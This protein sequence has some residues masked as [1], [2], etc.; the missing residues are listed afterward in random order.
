MSKETKIP[1]NPSA[2]SMPIVNPDA[3]GVDISATMHAVAVPPDRDEVCTREFGAF[4]QDLISIAE[5]LKKCRITTVAMESTGVYWKPLYTVLLEYGFSVALVNA[6]HV[7]NVTGR[8]NDM[9]D[10]RWIQKLHSCG[11]LSSSFLP[12]DMTESLRVLVRHRKRLIADSSKYVLRIQKAFEMMNIKIH[13]VI[14]DL[15]GK[16]GSAILEAI[17]AGERKADN[18]MQYVDS[19]IKADEETIKKSLTGNWRDEQIFMVAENYE[20]Y[21]YVQKKIIS[22]EDK[23]EQY[24]QKQAAVNNE[25]FIENMVS[26]P[27]STSKKKKTKNQPLFNVKS[28]LHKI[29]GVDVTEIFGISENTALEIFAETGTDLSKWETEKHFVSW[30][31]VCPNNKISGGKLISSTVMKKKASN[32]TQ[33]F[34]S[35][36]NSLQRSN[37]WLGDYFRRM[38]AKGGNKYAIVAT[39]RKIAI[40]YYRMVRYKENFKPIDLEQFREKYK[41]AKIA[42][43]KKQLAKL[44]DAA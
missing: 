41:D 19:R 24:L 43:L 31:N 23:I 6:R 10:A 28:Y 1:Q 13:S 36:A 17:I 38:K 42:Y 9:D 18:F 25:G 22:C 5:W 30:L 14:N 32:A 34:R 44:E 7:K 26:E 2:V 29:N 27:K 3:A 40:I 39:A 20:L 16:T 4:T 35:A 21:K 33:A 8:K 11:L 12:D 15:M 37:H